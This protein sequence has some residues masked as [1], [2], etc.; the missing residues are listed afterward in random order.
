MIT[1]RLTLSLR[2]RLSDPEQPRVVA[3]QVPLLLDT[4]ILLP[5][6]ASEA[7]SIPRNNQHS[8]LK[9]HLVPL[10]MRLDLRAMTATTMTTM[11]SLADDH[12]D[13]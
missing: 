9:L 13:P 12:E 7:Q 5:L 4:K 10:D 6:L 2:N 1:M 8:T 3:G 11:S